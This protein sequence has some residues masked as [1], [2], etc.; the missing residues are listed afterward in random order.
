[1]DNYDY[2]NEVWKDIPDWEGLYQVSNL[3]RVKVLKRVSSCGRKL[4]EKIMKDFTTKLGYKKIGLTR[5]GCKQVYFRVHRLVLLAFIGKSNLPIDHINSSPSDNRLCN[6][7]YVTPRENNSRS[8][9]GRKK[10]RLPTGVYLEHGKYRAKIVKNRKHISLGMF[11]CPKEAH[12][13]YLRKLDE[14]NEV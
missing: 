7:E 4:K 2:S 10:S 11:D 5:K 9:K 14:F 8:W 3:G 12:S 6:L 1:M 13:A